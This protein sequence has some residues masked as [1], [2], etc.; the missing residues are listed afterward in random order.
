MKDAVASATQDW[1]VLV[2]LGL[3]VKMAPHEFWSGV[4]LAMAAAMVAR[5]MSPERDQREVWLVLIS[6]VVLAI[7]TAMLASYL[8]SPEHGTLP[9]DFPIQMAM[10][11]SGFF[12][13]FVMGLALRMAGRV[14]TKTDDITDRVVDRF[15]PPGDKEDDK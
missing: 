7:F 11:A 15:L 1:G 5:K 9:P 14:E 2:L 3:G 6:A 4:L 8:R 12:S 13:R 10:A